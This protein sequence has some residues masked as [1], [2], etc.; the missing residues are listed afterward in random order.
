MKTQ[1]EYGNKSVSCYCV[2]LF[3]TCILDIF[4]VYKYT[5]K[6]LYLLPASLVVHF[7]FYIFILPFIFLYVLIKLSPAVNPLQLLS[8]LLLNA[9]PQLA[10]RGQSFQF[11]LGSRLIIIISS[12]LSDICCRVYFQ[13][14]VGGITCTVEG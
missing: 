6:I 10:T 13:A 12:S 8:G 2:Q 7:L 3:T 14:V 9:I 11:G 5:L 1:S 4:T